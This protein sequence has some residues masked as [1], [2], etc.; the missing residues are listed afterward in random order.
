MSDFDVR[1]RIYEMVDG[2]PLSSLLDYPLSYFGSCPNV[3]DT[4]AI[5][6]AEEHKFFSVSRRYNIRLRGWAIIVRA[7]P[8]SAQIAAVMK[9]WKEDD[10]WEA[11]IDAEE[12]AEQEKQRRKEDERWQLISNKP[13]IEFALDYWEEPI[14][15]RL[16]KI[17]VGKSVRVS[18]LKGLGES[19]R[20]KLE[21][22]GFITVQFGQVK[23][24]NHIVTLTP[25][26]AKA[27]KALAAY[28]KKVEAAR[29]Q[30]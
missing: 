8:I 17:G 25:E 22:R 9:A 6:Y 13:P 4:I 7:V 12:R 3:G 14:I 1:V 18:A 30:R 23:A 11:K 24:N 27:L 26:G 2:E 28:R 21:M 16:A 15:K 19:T 5:D 29:A 20:K 10:D